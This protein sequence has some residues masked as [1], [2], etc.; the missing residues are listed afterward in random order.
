MYGY[1]LRGLTAYSLFSATGEQLTTTFDGFGRLKQATTN[2]GGWYRPL[3][4][5]YDGDGHRTRI[6]YPDGVYFDYSYDGLGRLKNISE[7]GNTASP[8]ITITY[9]AQGP[10]YQVIRGSSSTTTTYAYDGALRLSS[11]SQD[12]DGSATSNDLVHS[13]S[14]NPA[15]QVRTRAFSNTAYEFSQAIPNRTYGINGLNQY[16]QIVGATT[17]SYDLNG[18]LTFD[19][20]RTFGYDA[21]NRL[22]SASGGNTLHYDPSGRLFRTIGITTTQ[23]LHDGDRLVA[24]YDANG[25]M[26]RR[27]VPG[28][29]IDEFLIR[30]DG[31]TVSSSNRKFL[32]YDNQGSVIA[33]VDN[34]GTTVEKNIY[35]PFGVPGSNSTSRF[36]YSG[37]V[38]I[39]E[40][41]L[42]YY[43]ARF[44]NPTLGRFMQTDPVGY[45]DD[46]NLYT[47]AANDPVNRADPQGTEEGQNGTICD[48]EPQRCFEKPPIDVPPPL[49]ED[50]YID[51]EGNILEPPPGFKKED[52]SSEAADPNAPPKTVDVTKPPADA[53]VSS[54][55]PTTKEAD[56]TGPAGFDAAH[57]EWV[58]ANEERQA[59]QRAGKLK[60]AAEWSQRA[61]EAEIK[62]MKTQGIIMDPKMYGPPTGHDR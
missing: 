27:Y 3:N 56:G 16:T 8:L 55:A 14:F 5:Q 15:N 7:N 19:G 42:Y 57:K 37:Q 1:D 47:Y 22:V 44:Y 35:D 52:E 59:A 43:K 32:H 39:P 50:T 36:R 62:M 6:V 28:S 18:N 10:R 17:F 30:Y 24:E 48:R 26:L 29:R 53:E 49:G 2:M 40:L 41:G 46:L 11:L 51:D 38:F 4:Y 45:A 9:Y 12:L 61:R 58:K 20:A 60:D 13:F 34:S 23:F 21:E 54:T 33:I 31:A 25:A